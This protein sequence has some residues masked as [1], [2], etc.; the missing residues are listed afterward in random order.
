MRAASSLL[1]RKDPCAEDDRILS[2][3]A[4]GTYEFWR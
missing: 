1:G 3:L 2:L 4:I